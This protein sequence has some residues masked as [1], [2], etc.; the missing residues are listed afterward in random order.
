MQRQNAFCVYPADVC[1][2]HNPDQ[3]ANISHLIEHMAQPATTTAVAAVAQSADPQAET[4]QRR[5]RDEDD[6]AGYYSSERQKEILRESALRK[7]AEAGEFTLTEG[8]LL[9]IADRPW[10]QPKTA[11]YLR[12]EHAFEVLEPTPV[13]PSTDEPV[14]GFCPNH[15]G[16]CIYCGRTYDELRLMPQRTAENL[17]KC[18]IGAAARLKAKEDHKSHR[19]F[20]GNNKTKAAGTG[21]TRN[22][23][24]SRK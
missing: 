13:D 14:Q 12:I 1:Y 17:V 9:G 8:K 19:A 11:P 3:N 6:D 21:Y 2:G 18:S 23:F 10:F 20:Q 24:N 16:K 5:T 15:F 22:Y 7:K 4:G